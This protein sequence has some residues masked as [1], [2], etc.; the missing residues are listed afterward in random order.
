[1]SSSKTICILGGAGFLGSALYAELARDERFA[2]SSIRIVDIVQPPANVSIRPED[3]V[4]NIQSANDLSELRGCETCINLAGRIFVPELEGASPSALLAEYIETSLGPIHSVFPYIRESLR[5]WVQVSSISV[6]ETVNGA[7]VDEAHPTRPTSAYGA[8]K[9]AAE[10]YLSAAAPNAFRLKILRFPDLFG[11]WP[12]A[13]HDRRLYPEL[14]RNLSL[15]R[16]AKRFGSGDEK[17]EWLHVVDAARAVATTLQSDS[18]GVWN[19]GSDEGYSFNE[20]VEAV[21]PL[22]FHPPVLELFPERQ[23]LSFRLN[24]SK[25]KKEFAFETTRQFRDTVQEDFAFLSGSP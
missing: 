6:Y 2:N 12:R 16:P 25:F 19:V 4:L 22:L 8:G 9:L 14:L 3:R 5:E 20:V 18:S 17:K 7:R 10:R 24:S 1:M 13:S 11:P 23:A 21:R 15:A